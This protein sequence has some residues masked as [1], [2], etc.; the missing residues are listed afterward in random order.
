MNK[1]L[2]LALA[3]LTALAASFHVGRASAADAA[4]PGFS[5][6]MTTWGALKAAQSGDAKVNLF[7]EDGVQYSAKIK[8]L[9]NDA[10]VLKEPTG[11]E[12]YEVYVP[13]EKVIAVELK[14][15]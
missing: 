5:A 13:L 10:V 7:L 2:L 1:N 8:D 11:K 4:K 9:G 14:V 6:S 15:K 12:Y 3:V